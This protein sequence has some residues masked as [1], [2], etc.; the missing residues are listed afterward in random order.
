MIGG[1]TDGGCRVTR[2]SKLGLNTARIVSQR[3]DEVC[4]SQRLETDKACTSAQRKPRRWRFTPT[5]PSAAD[6]VVGRFMLSEVPGR[7]GMELWLA[8]RD[9]ELWATTAAG[10]RMDLFATGQATSDWHAPD[11]IAVPLAYLSDLATVPDPEL[12]STACLA[13]SGWAAAEGYGATA[14]AFG[15]AAANADRASPQVAVLAGLVAVRFGNHDVA[16]ACLRRGL[17]LSRSRQDWASIEACYAGL[18]ELWVGRGYPDRAEQCFLRSARAAR[19]SGRG[20]RSG[21]AAYGLFRLARRAGK[22]DLADR[23]RSM[24]QARITIAEES[25]S[26]GESASLLSGPD[27]SLVCCDVAGFLAETGR[28]AAAAR[29]LQTLLNLSVGSI[30]DRVRVAALLLRIAGES[31]SRR[32]CRAAWDSV[33]KCLRQAGDSETVACAVLETANAFIQV[34]RLHAGIMIPELERVRSIAQIGGWQE[35]LTEVERLLVACD[36]AVR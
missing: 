33:V 36:A 30:R 26:R 31:G 7:L 12:V 8:Y 20:R 9:A 5:L 2:S 1:E 22:L 10:A 21:W 25:L 18:G 24:V 14:I 13:I 23:Y 28:R 11:T 34:C 17:A 6:E 3:S 16:D 19:L 15:T 32:R 29:L 27:R 35:L 4:S